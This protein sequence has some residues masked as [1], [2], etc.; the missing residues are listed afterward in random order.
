MILNSNPKIENLYLKKKILKNIEKV[1][2]KGNYILGKKVDEFEKKFSKYINCKYAVAVNSGLDALIISLKTLN[3]KK[4][5]EVI[6]PS[7]SASA[8]AMAVINAGA[9]L[10]YADINLD[11]LNICFDSIKKK[12][13]KKTKAIIVVHLNGQPSN[14]FDLKKKINNKKIKII[15]DCA[16][17]HGA[18]F[19]NRLV[20]SMGDFGCFSFYPTKNLSCIGDG[21]LITTS[22]YKYYIIAKQIR[23]YGWKIRDNSEIS[24]MNSRLDEMQ[25]SILLLKLKFLNRNNK[26]RIRIAEKYNKYLHKNKNIFLP[27]IYKYALN[28]FHHYVIRFNKINR[29]KLIKYLSNK[30]VQILVHYPRPLYKQKAIKGSSSNFKNTEIACKNIISLPIY[31]GLKTQQIKKISREINNYVKKNIK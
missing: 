25:A 5:D 11:N 27:K 24:G 13:T 6:I 3:I 23:Q 7:L 2:H 28:V 17:A 22:N 10:V 21:G 4:N 15:E 19:K 9:K 29:E 20:G 18:K 30:G 8:T 26:E 1:I 12:I 16:Q 14:I 31:P